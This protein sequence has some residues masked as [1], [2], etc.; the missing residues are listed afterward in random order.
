[1]C[2]EGGGDLDGTILLEGFLFG[3]CIG[4]SCACEKRAL[5]QGLGC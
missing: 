4:R 3:F 1:M 2:G 5:W